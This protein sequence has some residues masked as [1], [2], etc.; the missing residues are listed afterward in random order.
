VTV[1]DGIPEGQRSSELEV[2]LTW[3]ATPIETGLKCAERMVSSHSLMGHRSRKA[4]QLLW[5]PDRGVNNQVRF[6]A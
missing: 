2:C 6:W 4:K 1:D 3:L 5:K